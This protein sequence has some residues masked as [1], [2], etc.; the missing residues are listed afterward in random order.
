MTFNPDQTLELYKR[1][2]GLTDDDL[3]DENG[4]S[5]VD[6][7]LSA[8]EDYE[9]NRTAAFDIVAEN[10]ALLVIDM[11][12]G[13]TRRTSPQW[14]PQAERI[15]PKL[16]SFA[17]TARSLDIPVI[18][19]S[20]IYLDPSPHDGLKMTTAIAEGNLGSG[21]EGLEVESDLW[22]DGDLLIDTK[23]TYDAFWGSN[24]DYHLRALK[25]D[26][27]IITGTMTNF[28]CEATSRAGFDRGYHVLVCSDLC[29]SDNPWA[30]TASMQ[31]LRRGYGRVLTSDEIVSEFTP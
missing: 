18:F 14:I 4:K 9:I 8:L 27:L 30:H 16:N 19:T 21:T 12:V 2:Y 25:K 7:V 3:V 28:C 1:T 15:I 5:E 13:F 29:A 24:L 26:T 31:T 6:V 17:E 10:C 22:R 20:A 23:H 11:Q